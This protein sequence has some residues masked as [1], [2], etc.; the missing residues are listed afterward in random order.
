MGYDAKFGS[1]TSNGMDIGRCPE[2]GTWTPPTWMTGCLV[3]DGT[4]STKRLYRD[5][6]FSNRA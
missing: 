1:S 4:F 6:V 5:M 3:F 2:M